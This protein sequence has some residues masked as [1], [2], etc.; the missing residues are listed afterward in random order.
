[1]PVG[2]RPSLV[3]IFFIGIGLQANGREPGDSVGFAV[4]L[5]VVAIVTKAVGCGLFSRLFG[6]T[7]QE[8]IRVSA[9]E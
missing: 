9:R 6:F 1:M 3:P 2:S 4:A 5:L 8:S 7:N